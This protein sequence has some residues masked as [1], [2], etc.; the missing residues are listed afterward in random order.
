MKSPRTCSTRQ[1]LA[2]LEDMM[3]VVRAERK[4]HELN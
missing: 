4:D 1:H 2:T 3:L